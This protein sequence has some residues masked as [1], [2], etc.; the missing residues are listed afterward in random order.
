MEIFFAVFGFFFVSIFATVT[1]Y[2][3]EFF[4]YNNFFKIIHSLE[5]GIFNKINIL[6]LPIIIWTMI[7]LPLLGNKNLLF[8]SLLLN[9]TISSAI[10]YVIKYGM[11]GL[12][13]KVGNTVNL[14]SIYIGA[15]VGQFISFLIISISNSNLN[16]FIAITEVLI[17]LILYILIML[18][19]PRTNFF[20]GATKDK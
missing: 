1:N 6:I 9:I 15:F 18:F 10:V 2:L 3:Y 14:I 17:I 4:P 16:V 7:E 13:E 11:F 12:F 20:T 5:E 8:L 19:P